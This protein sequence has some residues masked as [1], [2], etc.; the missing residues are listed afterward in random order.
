[1]P[2]STLFRDYLE[3]VSYNN[4]ITTKARVFQSYVKSLGG[5]LNCC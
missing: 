2:S 3:M 5:K 1:M 4:S